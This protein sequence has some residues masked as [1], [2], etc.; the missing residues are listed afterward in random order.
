[1][2]S[3]ALNESQLRT[4]EAEHADGLTSQ[5]LVDVFQRHEINFSEANLRRYV[6]LGLV[7][8]SRRV[9]TKGRHSGSRGLYPVRAVRRI[10]TI[11]RLMGERHT[12]EEIQE[13]FLT[14]KDSIETLDEALGDLLTLF[15]TR[16]E[17]HPP[18]AQRKRLADELTSL[19]GSADTLL[20]AVQRFEKLIVSAGG[21]RRPR[22]GGAASPTELL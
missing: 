7:P 11:K 14:F 12:L 9:G 16:L 8:R 5:Q 17:S 3:V 21:A 15:E 19:K 6:Q 22:G 13:K 18:S 4:I 10:N 2:S 1:M 20:K